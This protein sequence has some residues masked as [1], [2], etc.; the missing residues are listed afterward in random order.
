MYHIATP[1]IGFEYLCSRFD[2]NYPT[3]KLNLHKKINLV[4]K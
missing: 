2:K 3:K 4:A 1:N